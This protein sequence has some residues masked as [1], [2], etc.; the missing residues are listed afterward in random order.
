MGHHC[1]AGGRRLR[2]RLR[3]GRQ[4][5]HGHHRLSGDAG[6]HGG[7][8]EQ[9]RRLGGLRTLGLPHRKDPVRRTAA[10]HAAG[11]ADLHRRLLQ[12]PDGGRC[13]AAR[14]REPQNFPCQAG[15]PHRR[16]G[17]PGVHD[18]PGVLVGGGGIRLCAV[19]R[20]QRHRDVHQ[21]DPVELL[22]S[23]DVGDDRGAVS[24]EHR[25][26]LHADP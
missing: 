1:G 19:R 8:D 20:R 24:D 3:A 4:R 23:A 6:H 9:G 22:L 14:H 25:L 13:D 12:L 10:D 5:Q 26:R 2:H 15:L 11:R 21:A 17:G 16:H 18:R 7:S